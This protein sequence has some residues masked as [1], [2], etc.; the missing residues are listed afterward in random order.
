MPVTTTSSSASSAAPFAYYTGDVA[1]GEPSTKGRFDGEIFIDEEGRRWNSAGVDTSEGNGV[2]YFP[3]FSSAALYAEVDVLNEAIDALV[4][5]M[6]NLHPPYI[7]VS[8]LS[9]DE[10]EGRWAARKAISEVTSQLQRQAD[11]TA[12]EARYAAY[13]GR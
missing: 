5:V 4:D 13:A 1:S 11:G 10:V 3:P 12:D 6:A 9:E 2:V 8:N 7:E